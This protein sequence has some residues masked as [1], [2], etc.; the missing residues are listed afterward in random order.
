MHRYSPLTCWLTRCDQVM[1]A[2]CEDWINTKQCSIK[3][4]QYKRRGEVC[5]TL[6]Y[7]WWFLNHLNIKS[8]NWE[9][10]FWLRQEH[11][12]T[13]LRYLKESLG[14]GQT[15]YS[16]FERIIFSHSC[17]I[18]YFCCSVA[19]ALFCLFNF[20]MCRMQTGMDC[21]HVGLAYVG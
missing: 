6:I 18:L 20:I 8:S 2:D 1:T 9:S 11:L 4:N 15:N 21:R 13:V 5:K 16:I 7:T 19:F 12:W 14:T 17:I 3:S 10:S